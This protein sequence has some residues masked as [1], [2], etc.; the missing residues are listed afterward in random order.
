MSKYVQTDSAMCDLCKYG[1]YA[2]IIKQ[3]L[4]NLDSQNLENPF[5]ACNF[6]SKKS[7]KKKKIS[8]RH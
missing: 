2:G 5:F 3:K 1:N 8:H 7:Q 4:L 6:G